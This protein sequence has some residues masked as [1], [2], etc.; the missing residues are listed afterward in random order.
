MTQKAISI[1]AFIASNF[2]EE[3]RAVQGGGMDESA[4]RAVYTELYA[5]LWRY[6]SRV[7]GSRTLAEDLVQEAFLRFIEISRERPAPGQEKAY[8]FRIATRLIY[9][10][11]RRKQKE[12][13]W[14]FRRESEAHP[15]S[16]PPDGAEWDV[17]TLF[18][19]L[20][21]QERA[22]LWLAYVEGSTHNEIAALLGL[23]KASIRVLLYRARRKWLHL[24]R[25]QGLAGEPR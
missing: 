16:S 20:K 2:P 4:F 23:K 17:R 25:K 14:N 13:R 1:E 22:L 5:P 19:T 15:S 7:S 11:W 18:A 9:D 8:L 12:E 21:P 10:Q 3:D 24:L 6:V